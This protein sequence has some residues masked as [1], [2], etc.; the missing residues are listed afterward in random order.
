MGSCLGREETKPAGAGTK[1]ATE[2]DVKSTAAAPAS[3]V[4]AAASAAR[5]EK[6][7]PPVRPK[8]TV[9]PKD[10]AVLDVKNG[11]DQLEQYRKRTDV[12]IAQQD[13]VARQL[14]KEGK[15]ERA[16]LALEMK[17]LLQTK[18]NRADKQLR[19]VEKLLAEIESTALSKEIIEGMEQGNL[20]L[21]ELAKDLTVE[22]VDR[23]L[24]ETEEQAQLQREIGDRLAANPLSSAEE[25]NLERELDQLMALNAPVPAV[26][27]P[28]TSAVKNASNPT[29]EKNVSSSMSHPP[30]DGSA[31]TKAPK[32]AA[33]PVPA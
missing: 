17:Q 6:A 8:V 27:N 21:K 29:G 11:R 10:Q 32:V 30:I 1:A 22:R 19:N 20:V 18:V 31:K 23:L 13:Q 33:S 5:V 28:S 25:E 15:L 14:V 9:T 16:K 26:A 3:S 4:N 24:E 7:P 2:K 12:A